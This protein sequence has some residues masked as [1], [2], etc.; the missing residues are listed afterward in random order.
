[1]GNT[2]NAR[3]RVDGR[4]YEGE[5]SVEAADGRLTINGDVVFE[6]GDDRASRSCT[7]RIRRSSP[8]SK[9]PART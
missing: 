9:K 1:M 4:T 7:S 2:R 5:A 8:I 3:L 6:L